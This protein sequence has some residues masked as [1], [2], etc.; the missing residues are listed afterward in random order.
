MIPQEE[1]YQGECLSTLGGLYY[2]KIP[3]F[4]IPGRYRISFAVTP[5]SDGRPPGF[6]PRI[7]T[8]SHVVTV[9]AQG[10]EEGDGAGGGKAAAAAGAMG[11]GGRPL[12]SSGDVAGGEGGE[13]AG[14]SLADA[15]RALVD[16]SK[17]EAAALAAAAA[18]WEFGEREVKGRAFSLT[19]P[20]ELRC[21]VCAMLCL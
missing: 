19:V 6:P 20:G 17:G 21:V 13:A 1:L 2:F 8:I 14:G 11:K 3:S 15:Y 18:Q 12:R 10:E 16:K 4:R 5:S 9:V 7:Q